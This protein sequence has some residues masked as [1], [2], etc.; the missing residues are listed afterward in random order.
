MLPT[1]HRV[2]PSLEIR[3]SSLPT[4]E[5]C[6]RMFGANHLLESG[7][8]NDMGL[9]LRR[10]R[11]HIGAAVGT[12]CHHG[13]DYLM[14]AYMTSG[15]HGGK[16]RLKHAEDV[17]LA[18]LDNLIADG[19]GYDS[20]TPTP[21]AATLSTRRM[22]QMLF[23]QHRPKAKPLLVEKGL[24][25]KLNVKS[26]NGC[27]SPASM[28]LKGTLD[29]Y[30]ISE[31]LID[32][33]TGRWRPQAWAQMGAYSLILRAHRTPVSRTRLV[34][35]PRTHAAQKQSPCEDI[36]I[37][38]SVAEK[39]ASGLATNAFR[40]MDAMITTGDVEHLTANPNTPLCDDRFCPAFGTRFCKLGALVHPERKGKVP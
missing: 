11:T 31:E 22:V 7:L 34:Y 20:T 37:L 36:P 38:Q 33:K 25:T 24:K 2:M 9:D 3:A 39:H 10:R 16:E 40:S 27:G 5:T 19:I 8:A 30:L 28:T 13:H 12:A 35:L 26:L 1:S 21:G 4:Y 6:P 14:N 23:D 18:T 32:L 29:L 17:T 15:S